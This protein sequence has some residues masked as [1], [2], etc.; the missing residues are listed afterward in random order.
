M[1]YIL[2]IYYVH[3]F[4]AVFCNT[5]KDALNEIEHLD[6]EFNVHKVTL[7]RVGRYV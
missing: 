7:K 5:L 2:K 6:F 3:T 1:K 4:E